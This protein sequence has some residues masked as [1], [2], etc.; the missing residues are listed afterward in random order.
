MHAIGDSANK[1]ALQTFSSILPEG[2]DPR[3]R[4]EHAQITDAADFNYYKSGKI[5]PSVQPTHATS[6]MPWAQ[7]RVGPARIVG[8]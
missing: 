3:W 1:I 8:A 7:D 6:D 2:T 5:I 4:I